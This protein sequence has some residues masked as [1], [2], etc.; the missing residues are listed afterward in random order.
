MAKYAVSEEGVQALRAAATAITDAIET[1]KAKTDTVQ[2]D[3]DE[4]QETLG[5]HKASLDKALDTI[6]ENIQ[7]ASETVSNVA[8]KLNGV[9]DKYQDVIDDDKIGAAGG[10][11]GGV[12]A[13]GGAAGGGG[14]F[15]KHTDKLGKD[16][17]TGMQN[18]LNKSPHSDVK[19]IYEKYGSQLE[20]KDPNYSGGAF[21]RPGDGVYMNKGVVSK[22][23]MIHTPYQTAFHEFGH[24]IDYIMGNGR[25]ISETWNN[26]E[27][28][29]A[30]KD[31]FAA[32]KGTKSNEELVAALKKEAAKGGWSIKDIGSVSDI[33]ESM[34]GISYPL[35]VGHGSSYW[36]GRL[37]CKEFFAEVL[38]GAAA[39][40]GSYEF[41]KKFFPRGVAVV[42]KILGGNTQ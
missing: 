32:L 8:A 2:S 24:N 3:A 40:K 18:T 30:I 29:D 6:A 20:I 41:M 15:A 23:D 16:F 39:N 31:D 34:T 28:M 14:A 38:D 9:A 13:A 33:V 7:Q 5:P 10:V 12:A 11:A 26:G 4:Y 25:A 37:P 35:G 19:R 21:Y 36:R 17:V 1:I 42:H 22:G 27:L